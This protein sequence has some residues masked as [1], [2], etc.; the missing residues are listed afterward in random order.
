MTSVKSTAAIEAMASQRLPVPGRDVQALVKRV[1]EMEDEINQAVGYL[2]RNVLEPHNADPLNYLMGI[3][4]QVDH[5]TATARNAALEEAAKVAQSH[6]GQYQV[7]SWQVPEVISAQI[8][9]RK[10]EVGQP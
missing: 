1:R 8:R 5:I 10:S 4:T 6:A 3:C 7:A 2:K 9:A